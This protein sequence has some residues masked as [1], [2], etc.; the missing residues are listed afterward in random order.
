MCG[1]RTTRC[2]DGGKLEAEALPKG[3]GRLDKDIVPIES[4]FDDLSLLR[5]VRDIVSE[6]SPPKE[7]RCRSQTT[8]GKEA[9]NL[10]DVFLNCCRS[11][12]STSMH[13][14]CRD[15]EGIACCRS[16]GNVGVLEDRG[17]SNVGGLPL[18]VL[19]GAAA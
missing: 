13:E 2:N 18:P 15:R 11:V 19:A 10:N 8:L 3:G 17:G 1:K 7:R 5:P 6:G 4:R 16:C 12:N 14:F 9:A